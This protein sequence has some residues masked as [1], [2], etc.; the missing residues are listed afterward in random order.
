MLNGT[1]AP[2]RRWR[3]L[4]AQI[5]GVGLKAIG[6]DEGSPDTIEPGEASQPQTKNG[7][8]SDEG[9]HPRDGSKLALVIDLLRRAD[10]ATIADLTQATGWLPHTTRAALEGFAPTRELPE[11]AEAQALLA[12]L[13]ETQEVKA[14]EAQRQRRLHLQTQYGQAMM[15]SKGFAAEETNAAFARAAELATKSDDFS[16][17]FAAARGQWTVALVRG[18]LNSAQEMASAFL[19]E[20]EN[21][22]RLVEAGVVR[23]GLALISYL[24]GDFA[25]G[26]GPL[27]TGARSL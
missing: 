14:A 10:G 25:P 23:R 9:G 22:R 15:Y 7:P 11:I 17:R 24:V 4:R 27:R 2:R 6:V 20:A 8:S 1:A 5:S 21:E 3:R 19:Q 26:A 18:G 16:Q 12:A 13:A